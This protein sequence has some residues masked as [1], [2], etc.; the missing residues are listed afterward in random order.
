MIAKELFKLS[1][2]GFCAP[3][4]NHM[5]MQWKTK[6]GVLDRLNADGH[7]AVCKGMFKKETDISLFVGMKVCYKYSFCANLLI[8]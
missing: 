5:F 2:Y 6:V 1:S 8:P 7:T 3:S 4:N